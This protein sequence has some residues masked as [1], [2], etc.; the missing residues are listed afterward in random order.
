M[1]PTASSSR[2][3]VGMAG[4]TDTVSLYLSANGTFPFIF[5]LYFNTS[6][7]KLFSVVVIDKDTLHIQ[8]ADTPELKQRGPTSILKKLARKV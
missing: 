5:V 4:Y 6:L 3:L 2:G 7:P 8:V 1:S